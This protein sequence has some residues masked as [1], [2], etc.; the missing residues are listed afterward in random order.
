MLKYFGS[1]KLKRK[2]V[3]APKTRRLPI[4]TNELYRHLFSNTLP[5]NKTSNRRRAYALGIVKTLR[6]GCAKTRSRER[7]DNKSS[8]AHPRNW[9]KRTYVNLPRTPCPRQ[10]ILKRKNL[11]PLYTMRLSTSQLLYCG[12]THDG[13]YNENR[14]EFFRGGA[15]RTH[16]NTIPWSRASR[17]NVGE[18]SKSSSN[19]PPIASTC[20]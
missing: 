12:N 11:T 15:M 8:T 4:P 3:H 9:C 6:Y 18:S 16:D 10:L 20:E 19:D 7:A 17:R 1:E 2:T 13:Q 14:H 5:T